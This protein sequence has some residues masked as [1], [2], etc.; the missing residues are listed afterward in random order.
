[1]DLSWNETIQK[2]RELGSFPKDKGSPPTVAKRKRTDCLLLDWLTLLNTASKSQIKN[3]LSSKNK[4]KAGG[5]PLSRV[6]KPR[7]LD[8]DID[9]ADLSRAAGY[10]SES[11]ASATMIGT[12]RTDSYGNSSLLAEPTARDSGELGSYVN[13]VVV[14]INVV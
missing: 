13:V 1:M 7:I 12:V 5:L 11:I 4:C 3:T 9:T 8:P 6:T 10:N 2:A 14:V